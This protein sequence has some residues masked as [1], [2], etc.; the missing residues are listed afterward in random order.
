MSECSHRLGKAS[1]CSLVFPF[2]PLNFLKLGTL[3][4]TGY[5]LAK[6]KD[7]YGG[8]RLGHVTEEETF[9][10]ARQTK[11]STSAFVIKT[12]CSSATL[13]GCRA[14]NKLSVFGVTP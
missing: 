2:H 10:F 9:F 11:A 4:P 5:G 13:A 6:T 7:G 12:V 3:Y 8:L 14:T 1:K